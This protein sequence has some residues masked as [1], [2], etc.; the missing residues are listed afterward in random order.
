MSKTRLFPV[1]A[2]SFFCAAAG[3]LTSA[4]ADGNGCQNGQ[5]G[6]DFV[7]R[8][9]QKENCLNDRARNWQQKNQA[10]Q[11]ARQKKIADLRDKYENAPA[12][13]QKRISNRLENERGKLANLQKQQTD[14]INKWRQTP[15]DERTRANSLA[16][17]TRGDVSNFLNGH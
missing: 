3:S 9:A 15:S 17:K 7:G 2:L 16:D 11:E 14:R 8:L 12:A 5:T 6:N 4:Y 13:E 10:Q 1:L